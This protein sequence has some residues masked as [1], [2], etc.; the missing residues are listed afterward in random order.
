M[1]GIIRRN[2]PT[3]K[4]WAYN[5]LALQ[6]KNQ[7]GFSLA[8]VRGMR[9]QMR[10]SHLETPTVPVGRRFVSSRARKGHMALRHEP[11]A[12]SRRL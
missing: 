2:I 1:S 4:G 9:V 7:R 6:G 10:S 8:T 11:K 12:R 3:R 5:R